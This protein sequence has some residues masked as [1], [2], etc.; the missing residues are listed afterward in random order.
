MFPFIEIRQRLA[1]FRASDEAWIF[2]I[3]RVLHLRD[4]LA[5]DRPG[6]RKNGI[7]DAKINDI[8]A[9]LDH[10]GLFLVHFREH[11]RRDLRDPPG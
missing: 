6:R 3:S 1:E 8:D 7:A 9:R 2:Q 5:D 11:V 4:Q 10:P